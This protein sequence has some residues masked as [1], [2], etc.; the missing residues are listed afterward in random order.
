MVLSLIPGM[1]QIETCFDLYESSEYISSEITI[2]FINYCGVINLIVRLV[3][4]ICVVEYFLEYAIFQ[5]K[6]FVPVFTHMAVVIIY[7]PTP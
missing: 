1:E 6:Y 3:Q 4:F 2:I 5:E 7:E